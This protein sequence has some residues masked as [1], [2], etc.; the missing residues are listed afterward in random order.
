MY[1]SNSIFSIT[2]VT[3][4]VNWGLYSS[5]TA[6]MHVAM[7]TVLV[8]NCQ[9]MTISQFNPFIFCPGLTT[10]ENDYINRFSGITANYVAIPK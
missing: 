7:R 3:K 1:F 5:R 6:L 2:R 8:Y 10:L 4:S 9:K